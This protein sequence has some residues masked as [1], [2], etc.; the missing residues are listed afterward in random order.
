MATGSTGYLPS[1][2]YTARDYATIRAALITHVQNFFPNDWQD[3]SESNLGICILELVAYVGDQLSFYLDRVANELFLPTVVQRANAINLVNLIG[4][5]PRSTAAASA[6]LQLTLPAIQTAAVTVSAYTQLTDQGSETWEILEDLSIPIG[7]L[8]TTGIA[9]T[10]EVLGAA[11]GASASYSFVTDNTNLTTTVT[12][13]LKMTIGSVLYSINVAVDGNISLP[14]G[15]I[16]ILDYNAGTLVLTFNASFVPDASTNITL[17]YAWDQDIVAH[18]G[19]TRIQQFTS[20]AT[21]GQE[22]TLSNSPVLVT[23]RVD[24]E[25]VTP[26]PNRFEV[27]LGDPAAPF[28]NG[29]GTLWSR[30]DSLITA[31]ETDES[32]DIVL[33]DQDNLTIRFGDNINGKVPSSGTINVIYRTGGGTVGNIATGY[34]NTSLTGNI[35]LF[36]I[37]VDVT[38]YEAGSGG[39]ER[40]SLNEIRVNAPAFIRTNDTATTE[41]DYDSLGL[42]SKSGVGAITRAKSRLTPAESLTTYTIHTDTVIGTIPVSTPLEYYI[43]LPAT[44][45]RIR[46]EATYPAEFTPALT[47]TIAG[48]DRIASAT[49]LGSGLANFTGAA[50]TVDSANTRWRYNT[51]NFDNETLAGYVGDGTTVSFTGQSLTGFP[52]F[53]SSVLFSYTIGGTD[54]VGYDDG[55]GALVGV[56]VHADS[57][58]N[59]DTGAVTLHFGDPATLAS[60]NP[61]TY[62]FNAINGGGAVNLYVNIDGSGVQT[63]NF[64]AGDAVAYNAVTAAEVVAVLVTGGLGGAPNALVG[65]SATVVA[66]GVTITSDTYGITSIVDVDAGANDANAALGFSVT[67]VTGTSYPLDAATVV[68]FDYQSCLHLVLNFAPDAGTEILIS[69]E[70][71]P[72]TQA[73]PTNNVEV[74]TWGQDALGDFVAPSSALQDHLKTFLDLR[75]VLGTSV[76]VL[77]GK[78][79]F[80]NYHF[81]ID[82]ETSTDSTVTTAL[83]VSTLEEYFSDITNINAGVDLPSAAIYD[84]IFPLP[85]VDSA[86]IQDVGIKLPIGVG[87]ANTALFKTDTTEPGQFIDTSRLPIVTGTGNINAYVGTVLAGSSDAATSPANLVSSGGVFQTLS[88]S[89]VHETTGAFTVK[90]TPAPGIGDIVY[91]DFLLDEQASSDGLSLWNI[92]TDEWEILALG[93]VFVNGTKVN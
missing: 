16:G 47:Y 9:V 41:Q 5:V 51:Q 25:P 6:A 90:L 22:F 7:R 89:T 75:R 74:Y 21:S 1:I 39:A 73:F 38:N 49:D 79:V 87:D 91:L 66:G 59:Y 80:M 93:D 29:T 67:A 92:S 26:D 36:S 76:E 8:T 53:P 23:A 55:S 58:V 28:G 56:N 72:N 10:D 61:Q 18:H 78:V 60:G 24:D 45:V 82:F 81:T 31:G 35:G 44:P 88:G 32:Y 19:K 50:A 27:W 33:D 65:A 43:L 71:G 40:E 70:S 2:D 20:D 57:T 84:A 54:Y 15:G 3:F 83:L 11:D 4:Y 17:S 63:I 85:G 30:V 68:S 86:V 14:F 69:M 64:V 77:S 48:V 37:T 13:V 52:I 12:P 34:L 42:F 62:D 46:D